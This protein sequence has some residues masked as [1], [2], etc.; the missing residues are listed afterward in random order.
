M[1]LTG[2]K[3]RGCLKGSPTTPQFNSRISRDRA[4]QGIRLETQSGAL[5][6]TR[7]TKRRAGNDW[8]FGRRCGPGMT[9]NGP[10]SPANGWTAIQDVPDCDRTAGK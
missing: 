10:A 9:W 4:R 8:H 1:R 6:P 3:K 2:F 5:T 7:N